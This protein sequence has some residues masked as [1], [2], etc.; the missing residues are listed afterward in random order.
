MRL[1][2]EENAY[3]LIGK[4]ACMVYICRPVH[5]GSRWACI[6]KLR[7]LSCFGVDLPEFRHEQTVPDCLLYN[8]TLTRNGASW[9]LRRALQVALVMLRALRNEP[10]Q[11]HVIIQ[12]AKRGCVACPQEYR[13]THL[14]CS[15][16]GGPRIGWLDVCCMVTQITNEVLD[17]EKW[18][19][20]S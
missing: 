12:F 7:L 5:K 3:L 9:Y 14:S 10:N 19:N 6:D 1:R 4:G 16:A 11:G 18:W 17:A 8:D 13:A 2:A 15:C 20:K